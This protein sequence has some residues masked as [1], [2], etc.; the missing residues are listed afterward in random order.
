MCRISFIR[1]DAK[2]IGVPAVLLLGAL[3]GAAGDDAGLIPCDIGVGG[4]FAS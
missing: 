2:V 3:A 1:V 4:L